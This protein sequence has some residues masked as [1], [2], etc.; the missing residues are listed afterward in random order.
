MNIEGRWK[1]WMLE[2]HENKKCCSI[3]LHIGMEKT[4]STAIQVWLAENREEL[5]E[6]KWWVPSTLGKINHRKIS[7]LGY[8][9]HKRDDATRRRK[10]KDNES[11]RKMKKTV[12]EEIYKEIQAMRNNRINTMIASSELISSRLIKEKEIRE[13]L[14]KLKGIGFERILVVLVRRNPGKIIESR[15]STSV[16][17]EG[18]YKRHPP[19]V[20]SKK[21]SKFCDQKKLQNRWKNVI[22]EFD[23]IDFDIINYDKIEKSKNSIVT[24]IAEMLDTRQELKDSAAQIVRNKP[25]PQINIQILRYCNYLQYRTANKHWLIEAIKNIIMNK[26][27]AQRWR[28]SLSERKK[29]EYNQHYSDSII[30]ENTGIMIKVNQEGD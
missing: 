27:I 4:G 10:I 29:E 9:D 2:K 20:G 1:K 3:I 28:Y 13:M 6:E 26:P 23:N 14:K 5:R 30:N 22:N 17:H 19:T 21:A 18:W 7:F 11:M 12:E 24:I 15:F 8:G 16:I 25:L